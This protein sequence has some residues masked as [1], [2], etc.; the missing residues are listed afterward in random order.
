MRADR[1]G[2]ARRPR[3]V[4]VAE[5]PDGAVALEPE[6]ELDPV[7]AARSVVTVGHRP[8]EEAAGI[9]HVDLQAVVGDCAVELE[10]E[11]APYDTPPA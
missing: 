3:L 7:D 6:P 8:P 10:P 11:R 9:G 2:S 5:H 4:P 1:N